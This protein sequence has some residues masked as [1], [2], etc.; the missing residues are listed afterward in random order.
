M[1][2]PNVNA[3]YVASTGACHAAIRVCISLHL[4]K[5]PTLLFRE[6][7]DI[8]QFPYKTDKYYIFMMMDD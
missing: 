8:F 4:L 1:F 6:Y 3:G 2:P 5:K 7:D